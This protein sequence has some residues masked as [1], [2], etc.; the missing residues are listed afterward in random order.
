MIT[1][2]PDLFQK[3]EQFKKYFEAN[4]DNCQEMWV[5]YKRDHHVHFGNTTNNN[6]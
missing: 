1:K 2:I 6:Y 3:N 4:W 5:T